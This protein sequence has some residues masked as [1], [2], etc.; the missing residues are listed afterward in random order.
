VSVP[1]AIARSGVS[2]STLSPSSTSRPSLHVLVLGALVWTL[3]GCPAHFPEP[4]EGLATPADA[5]ALMTDRV[6]SVRS[7]AVE[8]R[9]S[10][11]ARGMARKGGVE[12]A[13]MRPASLFFAALSPTGELLAALASDSKR[14]TSFERGAKTCLKGC[15]TPENIGRIIPLAMRGEDAVSVL[16]GVVPLI[17][18]QKASLSWSGSEGTYCLDIHGHDGLRQRVWIA[19]TTGLVHRAEIW[20]G[21]ALVLRIRYEQPREVGGVLLAHRLRVEMTQG[22]TDLKLDYR[23]VELN[24]SSL[25]ESAFQLP[26]P[27]GMTLRDLGCSE[28]ETK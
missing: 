6:K 3:A 22:K 24:P 18:A 20:R 27:A 12:I 10:Y 2:G 15:S 4:K 16:L 7:L 5:I 13:L 26:C 8:A 11:Y 17:K 9:A 25:N 14:F 21:E 1:P 23:E 19:P 28:V